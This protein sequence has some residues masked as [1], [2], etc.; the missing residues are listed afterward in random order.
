MLSRKAQMKNFLKGLISEQKTRLIQGNDK[1]AWAETKNIA[2]EA[3]DLGYILYDFEKR[4][5]M[6]DK[7]KIINIA[8][9]MK[10]ER[11]AESKT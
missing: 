9:T 2:Q 8:V 11:F 1:K 4:K 5:A 3:L 7:E 6:R 10:G